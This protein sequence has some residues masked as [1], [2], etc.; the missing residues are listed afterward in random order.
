MKGEEEGL[1]MDKEQ[2]TQDGYVYTKLKSLSPE[3]VLKGNPCKGEFAEY[4]E[5]AVYDG[6]SFYDDIDLKS[7]LDYDAEHPYWLP[8]LISHGYIEK[9]KVRKEKLKH[10]EQY[11]VGFFAGKGN[12]LCPR[13]IPYL[14]PGYEVYDPQKSPFMKL[15]GKENITMTL[16][17]EE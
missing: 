2:V 11:Q 6:L 10:T 15:V 1:D 14:M 16:T 13:G 8:W 7:V 5:T 12:G 3:S 4:V 17:W 9:E